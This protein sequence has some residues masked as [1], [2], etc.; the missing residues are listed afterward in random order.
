MFA[1]AAELDRWLAA[2]F[3]AAQVAGAYDPAQFGMLWGVPLLPGGHCVNPLHMDTVTGGV[4]IGC[5]AMQ[6]ASFGRP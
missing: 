5:S 3:W 4:S 6:F 2:Y 1:A